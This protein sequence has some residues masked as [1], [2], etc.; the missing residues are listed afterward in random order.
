VQSDLSVQG[1]GSEEGF[2]KE[3]SLPN[4]FFHK[5]VFK[6]SFPQALEYQMAKAEA[7]IFLCHCQI[8]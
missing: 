3:S 7:F 8:E 4:R 5:L 2:L 1:G 6:I